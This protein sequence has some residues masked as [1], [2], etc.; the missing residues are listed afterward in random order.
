MT[1]FQSFRLSLVVISIFRL[2]RDLI[3]VQEM[4]PLPKGHE[5]AKRGGY[6]NPKN[7]PP[8]PQPA[9]S[10]DKTTDQSSTE[11]AQSA[12]PRGGYEN[13]MRPPPKPPKKGKTTPKADQSTAKKEEAAATN[14]GGAQ[15]TKKPE[16]SPGK[17]ANDGGNQ[18]GYPIKKKPPPE[19]ND[20]QPAANSDVSAVGDVIC[21]KKV[22]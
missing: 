5:V 6:P 12:T 2:T 9:N 15:S 11:T 8:D 14:E 7:P 13:T 1:C 21:C 20:R 3:E 18:G 19:P 10:K 22:L 17:E 16:G 4:E